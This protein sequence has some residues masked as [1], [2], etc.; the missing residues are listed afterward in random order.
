MRK[1]Y[2]DHMKAIGAFLVILAHSISTYSE[3]F[4]LVPRPWGIVSNL[5]YAVN[6]TIFFV[7]AGYLCHKQDIP[8]FYYKKETKILIPLV[9]FSLLKIFYTMF[10]SERFAHSDSLWG[11]INDAFVY[12]RLYW[13]PYTLF[14]IFLAAPLFWHDKERDSKRLVAS[15]AAMVIFAG[16]DQYLSMTGKENSILLLQLN[17]VFKYIPYFLMGTVFGHLK[18]DRL[19][20]F[21]SKHIPIRLAVCEVLTVFF[22]YMLV[23]GLPAG[24]EVRVVWEL[25]FYKRLLIALPLIYMIYGVSRL[26][27]KDIKWL[28]LV[29]KRSLQILFFDS[30]FRTVLY[31]A[32]TKVTEHQLWMI[33]VVALLSIVLTVL[34]CE[35]IKRIPGIRTLVGL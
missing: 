28:E 34:S 12:G 5:C 29:G 10:L 22:G 17:N 31:S 23:R 24:D 2:I 18:G 30:I 20:S 26:L 3:S 15:V 33:P 1:T 11:M 7:I 35:V 32:L 25:P 13:F 19:E 27:P 21:L 6:A 9:S 14:V 4:K 8:R 16:W